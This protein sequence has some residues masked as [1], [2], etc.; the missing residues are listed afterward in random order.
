MPYV[1]GKEKGWP[2]AE[3]GLCHQSHVLLASLRSQPGRV[4]SPGTLCAS[5]VHWAMLIIGT[6]VSGD[7]GHFKALAVW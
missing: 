3:A 7:M 6:P 4:H 2:G 5:G 1:K